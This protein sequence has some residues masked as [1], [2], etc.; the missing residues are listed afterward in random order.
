VRDEKVKLLK[1]VR[2]LDPAR[3]VRGQ[4]ARGRV[5]GRE[6]PVAMLLSSLFSVGTMARSGQ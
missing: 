4:Y 1:A 5:D 3:M 2:P 6:V